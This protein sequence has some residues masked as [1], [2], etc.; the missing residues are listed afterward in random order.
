[1]AGWSETRRAWA[2]SLGFAFVVSFALPCFCVSEAVPLVPGHC[3][4]GA[5]SE[6][7]KAAKSGCCC[8]ARPDST[9]A[10]LRLT[11]TQPPAPLDS[12]RALAA[13]TTLLGSAVQAP[14]SRATHSPPSRT[15]LR[16]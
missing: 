4:G 10:K 2:L 11:S 14:I 8:I 15:I 5:A 3:G 1:M 16:I 13:Q 6:V 9:D 7:F 12:W